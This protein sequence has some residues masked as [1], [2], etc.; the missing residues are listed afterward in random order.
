MELERTKTGRV[1]LTSKFARR[2]IDDLKMDYHVGLSMTVLQE[3]DLGHYFCSFIN[4][5]DNLN[6]LSPEEKLELEEH[7]K[8]INEHIVSFCKL[9]D[10]I[11]ERFKAKIERILD[12]RDLL[13][14]HIEER[15]GTIPR[16]NK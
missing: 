8:I 11:D 5:T 7:A 2:C 14:A 3:R 15:F 1:K 6:L 12:N 13:E 4:D 10:N 16:L 9:G